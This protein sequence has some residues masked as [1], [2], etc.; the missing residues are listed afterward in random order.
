MSISTATALEHRDRRL[1]DKLNGELGPAIMALF[2]DKSD[3][4]ED[5]TLNS[6]GQLWLKRSGGAFK[7]FGNMGSSQALQ[8]MGTV[9]ASRGAVI[10]R[11]NPILETDMPLGGARF[12]AI[13]PPV[14]RAPIF[15]IR[16]R[17]RKVFRLSDYVAAGIMSAVEADILGSAITARKNIVIAGG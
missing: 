7:S 15:A 2:T 3:P 4:V 12:E 17:P 11:E 8:I 13:V 9:A 10:D 1:E 5:L 6:D 14:S 16:F